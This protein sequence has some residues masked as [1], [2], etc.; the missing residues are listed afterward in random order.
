MQRISVDSIGSKGG[1]PGRGESLVG[2]PMRDENTGQQHD[3]RKIL[4]CKAYESGTTGKG[5]RCARKVRKTC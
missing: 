5:T 3:E 1:R 4:T 2:N